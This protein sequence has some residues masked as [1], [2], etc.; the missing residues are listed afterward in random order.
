MESSCLIQLT[1]FRDSLK[2]NSQ[3]VKMNTIQSFMSD[4]IHDMELKNKLDN[5]VSAKAVWYCVCN[6]NADRNVLINNLYDY[7][8]KN[9]NDEANA[10]EL[11]SLVLFL[12]GT[13]SQLSKVLKPVRTR[14]NQGNNNG[15]QGRTV[16]VGKGHGGIKKWVLGTVIAIALLLVVVWWIAKSSGGDNSSSNLYS[17]IDV[18]RTYE[19]SIENGDLKRTCLLSVSTKEHNELTIRVINV[20]NQ[21][22]KKEY[23]GYI[24]KDRLEFRDGP[25]LIIK[26]TS[27][28]RITFS[29]EDKS[30]G[31]WSF[32]SK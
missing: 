29:C 23:V 28:G 7:F 22:D 18:C 17:I 26:K 12:G 32:I 13:D 16:G 31:K 9:G 11:T 8:V 1:E 2:N 30:Y 6:S 25:E 19:G 20:F 4:Y 10:L 3:W 21:N 27:K 14:S 24:K 5:P 15:N